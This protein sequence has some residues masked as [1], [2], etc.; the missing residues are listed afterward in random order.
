MRTVTELETFAEAFGRS[1]H[2]NLHLSCHGE[3]GRLSL[4]LESIS[5]SELVE[6]LS[7]HMDNRR[8]F[9]SACSMTDQFFAN[10]LLNKSKCLSVMGP[11][12]DIAFDDAA[13]FWSSLYHLMFK[14]NAGDITGEKLSLI[15]KR[16]AS[17]IGE[18]FRL[19]TREHPL[20]PTIIQPIDITL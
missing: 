4:S 2:K 20:G 14:E 12:G 10:E 13:I 11:A 3:P 7:P 18:K 6:I 5:S 1:P 17:L 8:L 19:F 9:V 15:L 16:C